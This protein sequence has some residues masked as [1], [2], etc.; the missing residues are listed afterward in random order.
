MAGLASGNHIVSY[1][2]D[3]DSDGVYDYTS[4][5]T[6]RVSHTYNLGG[7]W[8]S[9]LRVQDALGNHVYGSVTVTVEKIHP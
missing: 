5:I 3:F 6:P 7:T 9:V 2:W 1:E 8:T 4:T